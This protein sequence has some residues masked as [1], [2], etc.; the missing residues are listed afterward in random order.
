MTWIDDFSPATIGADRIKVA[1][2][3]RTLEPR[4]FEAVIFSVD[5]SAAD[6]EGGIVLPIEVVVQAPTIAGY[7]KK[8]YRRSAPS[9]IVY[10]PISSGP[11]LIR[12]SERWHNKVFGALSFA[13]SGDPLESGSTISGRRVSA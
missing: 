5:Y 9:E 3:P 2:D 1:L 13:V 10:F 8:I 6:A 4:A 7:V 11:H 12:V